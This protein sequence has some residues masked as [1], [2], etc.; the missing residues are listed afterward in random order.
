VGVFILQAEETTIEK[1]PFTQGRLATKRSFV[2]L[3]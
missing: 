2:V 1:A 3:L